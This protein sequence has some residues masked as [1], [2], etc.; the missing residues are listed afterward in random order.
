VT[1]QSAYDSN[2][3]LANPPT[4][5]YSASIFPQLELDQSRTRLHWL[6][7]Y[8]GG[9]TYN[10]QLSNH[11]QTSQN[12]NFDLRYRLTEHVNVRVSEQASLTTGF[13]GPV[14]SYNGATPGVPAGSNAFV[15]TPLAKRASTTTPGDISYQFS[16]VDVIGASGGFSRL[17]YRDVPVGTTL[18][19]TQGE[20]AAGYY[21]HRITANNWL[22]GSYVFNHFSYSP[23]IDESAIHSAIG[24]DTW[25]VRPGMNLSFFVGPQYSDNRFQTS[26]SPSQAGYSAMWTVA[27]GAEYSLTGRH[28]SLSLTFTRHLADGGGV[29]GTVEL[30][31]FLGSYR[32]QLSRRWTVTLNGS[33]GANDAL[34]NA[35]GSQTI[36]LG[37]A[38]LSVL[39]QLGEHYF[40]EVGYLWQDQN[41][42]N[43][44]VLSSN[45]HRNTVVASFSYQFA[46]PWGR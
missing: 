21:M 19:D 4:S 17:H 7:D 10:D 31:S 33:Y 14:S 23:V 45:A 13:F 30:S 6:L 28:N 2:A 25:Q 37:S 44:S 18:V 29:L 32:Q 1:L 5:N 38:G 40:V 12:V 22:G 46:R 39:R 41:T 42:K 11:N 35:V 3:L 20:D 27:A 15:L 26:S 9:F 8:A 16:S 34:T 36:D 24:F 43:V